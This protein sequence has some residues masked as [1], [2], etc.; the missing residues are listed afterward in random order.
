MGKLEPDQIFQEKLH[1]DVRNLPKVVSL[2]N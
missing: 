2:E 1:F